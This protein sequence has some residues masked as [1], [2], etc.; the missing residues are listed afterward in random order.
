MLRKIKSKQKLKLCSH[1]RSQN[2]TREKKEKLKKKTKGDEREAVG[3]EEIDNGWVLERRG[4]K[5]KKES[6]R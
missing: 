6:S 1:C 2:E 4:V 3:E 5:R